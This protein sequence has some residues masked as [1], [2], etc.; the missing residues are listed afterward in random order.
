MFTTHTV[1]VTSILIV[2]HG[3]SPFK[4]SH[5]SD[6]S[7]DFGIM[8][9]TESTSDKK[10]EVSNDDS[11]SAGNDKGSENQSTKGIACQN[12]CQRKFGCSHSFFFIVD[13]LLNATGNVPIMK[14]RRWAVDQEKPISW[15]MKFVHKYLK[16]DPEEKLVS[17]ECI[18]HEYSP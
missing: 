18:S 4:S 11:V 17:Y 6:K 2:S 7:K 12:E 15:I 1:P 10:P 5:R 16:L 13:I 9:E 14:K 8:S 3:G